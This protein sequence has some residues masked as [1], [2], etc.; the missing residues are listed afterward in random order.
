MEPAEPSRLVDQLNDTNPDQE[1]AAR[2]R[3]GD[4]GWSAKEIEVAKRLRHPNAAVRK[5]LARSLPEVVGLDAAPWLLELSRDADPDVRLE[6]MT[7]LA[8]TGD[9]ALVET[10]RKLAAADPDERIQKLSARL[11]QANSSLG[12]EH[13]K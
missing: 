10:V 5:A 4:L 3:L 7:L 6:A 12:K 13:S 1:A 8:T 9:P 11:A 2:K